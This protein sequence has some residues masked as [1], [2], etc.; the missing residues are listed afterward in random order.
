M[1]LLLKFLSRSWADRILLLRAFVL[2]SAVRVGL[3]VLPYRTVQRLV[4]CAVTHR[5]MTPEEE[6]QSLRQIVGA[7][8]AMSRRLL[9]TKPCLTQALAAQR[10]LRKRGMDSTLR[11][12]VA[13]DGHELLAH[14]WLER[15]GRVVIGGGNALARYTPLASVRSEVV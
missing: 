5:E 12:G 4:E 6:W 15:M 2:V 13:K 9:G 10:M 8:E 11:I 3:R 14:A 1:G 7:V